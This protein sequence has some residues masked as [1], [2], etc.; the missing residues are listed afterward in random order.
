[1][2]RPLFVNPKDRALLVPAKIFVDMH[3]HSR[4]SDGLATPSRLVEEAARQKI[5]L[6]ITDHCEIAGY[7][8][9]EAVALQ[10]KVLLIP[11]IE[12]GVAMS[13]R[14]KVD[15]L[16][17]F[18]TKEQ[19]VAFF[20]KEILPY[21]PDVLTQPL[22]RHWDK[23]LPKVRRFGGLAF[24]AHPFVNNNHIMGA[25]RLPK[26]TIKYLL[27]KLDGVEITNAG[28]RERTNLRAHDLAFVTD[29]MYVGGSD[30]HLARGVGRVLSAFKGTTI[31]EIFAELRAHQNTVLGKKHNNLILLFQGWPMF[32]AKLQRV[33]KKIKKQLFHHGKTRT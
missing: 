22:R 26:K 8:V 31:P 19:L 25:T 4:F 27:S 23:L 33:V 32:R 29:K 20:E 7:L 9:A 28:S 21:R 1:M 16:I 15:I 18:P 24:W 17:Y 13:S 11:A 12:V 10:K 5:G 30:A 14:R 2:P 6:A 3:V